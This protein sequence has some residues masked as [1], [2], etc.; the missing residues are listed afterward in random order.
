MCIW[1]SELFSNRHVD[2]VLFWYNFVIIMC[3]VTLVGAG[4]L[5]AT[6]ELLDLTLKDAGM[7]TW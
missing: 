5:K 4:G 6:N 1:H 3:I 2:F 7:A